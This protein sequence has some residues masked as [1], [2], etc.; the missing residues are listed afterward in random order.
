MGT[1]QNWPVSVTTIGAAEGGSVLFRKDGKLHVTCVLKSTFQLIP[2]EPMKLVDAGEL[3]ISELHYRDNPTR[4]IRAT[5]DVVP[6][7][8]RVDVILTGH[9]HA[10][11]GR[12]VKTLAVRLAVYHGITLLEKKLDVIGDRNGADIVPFER[13]PLV[14]EKALGGLGDT[15]NPFGTGKSPGS[16]PPNIIDPKDANAAAG[17][18]PISRALRQRKTLRGNVPLAT[19]DE[20]LVELPS[21]FDWNYFQAS[22]P[23][24][25]LASLL[26]NEWIVLEGMHPTL[27]RIAS[28]LPTIRPIASMFG[29][30]P[31][32]PDSTRAVQARIDMLRIDADNLT[33]SVVA[34]AIV[35]IDDE[36][37]LAKI[38]IVAAIETEE[39]SYAHL[40]APPPVGAVGEGKMRTTTRMAL[41]E[42]GHDKGQGTVL[43]GDTPATKKAL[44]FARKK[45]FANDGESTMHMDL[46]SHHGERNKPAMPFPTRDSQPEPVSNRAPIPGA[47]WSTEPAR[48]PTVPRLR[49][50]SITEMTSTQTDEPTRKFIKPDASFLMEPPRPPSMPAAPMPVIPPAPI[51]ELASP[52]VPSVVHTTPQSSSDAP[53]APK[54]PEAPTKDMWAKTGSELPIVTTKA[55]PPR[56]PAK[57]AVNKAIYGGFGPPKKKT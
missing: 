43:L 12:P 36:R 39:V 38:R 2:D 53:S 49:H 13:M 32:K 8:P 6:Y 22:P 45:Q 57:P 1:S 54:P 20:S 4:S 23:D 47:P 44:P 41:A 7:L 9:A 16:A 34:R 56:I 19:L 27:P 3:F 5:S 15:Q 17:F 40:L 14:Y 21:D 24:Q 33:C 11:N 29:M 37:T 26:G 35:P 28:R 55:P 52:K 10:P 18:G 31:G 51:P 46:A 25:R 30:D 42:E 48:A 50:D